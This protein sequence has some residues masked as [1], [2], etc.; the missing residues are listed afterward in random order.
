MK[1]AEYMVTLEAVEVKVGV[2]IWPAFAQGL[3]KALEWEDEDPNQPRN[4]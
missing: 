4:E 1:T 2:V 3:L